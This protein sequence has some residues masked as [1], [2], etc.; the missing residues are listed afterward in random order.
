MEQNKIVIKRKKKKSLNEQ[1][2]ENLLEWIDFFRFN[3]H[4]L[5]TDYY[6]LELYDF[7]KIVLY[8]MDIHEA[9]IFVGSRGIAKSTLTLLFAI[10]RA[11]LY[12]H[13]QIVIVA[14]TREQS[15]R[16]IGKVRE[17]MRDSPNLRAEIK[18]LHLSAQNSS[19]EFQ[20]GSKIFAVPYGENALG[21][22]R[23][24]YYIVI[25]NLYWCKIWKANNDANQSGSI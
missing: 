6:G 5:I 10:E 2:Q 12:P 22:Y 25:Y 9:E 20:N 24:P 17:F 15:G 8:E 19:I 21:K 18:E 13:Q 23:L 3:P 14:P 4:R 7:Q 11:T 16:F 1:Y